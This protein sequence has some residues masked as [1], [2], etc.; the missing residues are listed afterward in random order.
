MTRSHRTTAPRTTA[1]FVSGSTPRKKT[2]QCLH[3]L[4]NTGVCEL[5]GENVSPSKKATGRV[6]LPVPRDPS[7]Q[8]GR[9]EPKYLVSGDCFER[10]VWVSNQNLGRETRGS[11]CTV[12]NAVSWHRYRRIVAHKTKVRL[13]FP[14]GFGDSSKV[15]VSLSVEAYKLTKQA[16]EKGPGNKSNK[17]HAFYKPCTKK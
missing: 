8:V 13:C 1:H 2:S 4:A 10:A 14:F 11:E 7:H 3:V 6:Y 12:W 16:R 9:A 17:K 5:T 15:S